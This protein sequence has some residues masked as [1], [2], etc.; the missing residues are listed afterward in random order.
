MAM[1][2]WRCPD[3]E[4]VCT[5]GSDSYCKEE[6][7][8]IKYP[9][10]GFKM[11]QDINSMYRKLGGGGIFTYQCIEK[12]RKKLGD[13]IHDYARIIVFSDSQDIDVAHGSKNKPRPFGNYRLHMLSIF[14]LHIFN[15]ILP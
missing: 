11:F 14:S 9:S 8:Y 5:A 13:K 7:E 10:K 12:L 1:F 15:S 2:A 3:F 6:Q 4:L